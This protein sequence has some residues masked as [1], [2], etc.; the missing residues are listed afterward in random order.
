MCL[1]KPFSKDWILP[2]IPGE[3]L[4]FGSKPSYPETGY[5]YIQIDEQEESGFYK[6]KTFVVKSLHASL[7]RVFVQS[8]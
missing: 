6:V 2:P 3:L 8:S 4:T 1:K 5:G 7:L